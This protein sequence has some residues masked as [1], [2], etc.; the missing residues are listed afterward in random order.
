MRSGHLAKVLIKH[1]VSYPLMSCRFDPAPDPNQV[2][3]G[4]LHPFAS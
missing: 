1:Q 3:L 2:A 4:G